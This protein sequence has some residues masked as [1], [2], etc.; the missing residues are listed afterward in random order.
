MI[1]VKMYYFNILLSLSG[2]ITRV[3][4]NMIT[5]YVYSCLEMTW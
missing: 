1:F 4:S 3:S 5:L 2:K